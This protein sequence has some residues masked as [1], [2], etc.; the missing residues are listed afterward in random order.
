MPA[1]RIIDRTFFSSVNS[2]FL[3]VAKLAT[4][5]ASALVVTRAG[6]ELTAGFSDTFEYEQP[7]RLTS[8]LIPSG[9]R[10]ADGNHAV[11]RLE[12]EDTSAYRMDT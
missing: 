6:E 10:R 5:G 2:T 8:L 7:L 1:F 3:P 11:M 12:S 4:E 9:A